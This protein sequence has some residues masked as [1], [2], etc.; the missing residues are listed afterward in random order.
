MTDPLAA[1]YDAA[2]RFAR[3]AGDLALGR[4]RARDFVVERKGDGSDVTDADRAAEA[5]LR[6]RIEAAFPDDAILG[7][8]HGARPGRSGWRWV[9]DPID[10]TKSFVHG[11]PLWGTLVAVERDERPLA[12][13]IRLPAIDEEVAGGRDLGA[14]WRDPTGRERAARVSARTDLA[15]SCVCATAWDQFL[16]GDA[17]PIMARLAGAFG[18][19][20]GWSDCA[21]HLLLAT[22][23][24]EAVVEPVLFPWDV[25]ATV[26]VLEGAGGRWSDWYGS[27]EDPHPARAVLTNGGVHDATLVLLAG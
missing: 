7:E 17:L 12:G 24:C 26:A 20:R 9:L 2:R 10:G 6:K 14:T 3:E 25:A 11:V 21:A 22:G 16:R 13:V 27:A 4:F 18:T 8:E 15:D 23:R 1:R 5:L 19:A